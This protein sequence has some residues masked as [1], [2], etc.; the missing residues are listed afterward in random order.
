[1]I[2]KARLQ[3]ILFRSLLL[4]FFIVVVAACK[5]DAPAATAT[6]TRDNY[7]GTWRCTE[8]SNMGNQAFILTISKD[9]NSQ[10]YL[11]FYNFNMQGPNFF[12]NAIVNYA[13]ITIPTQTPPSGG[14]TFN[15][16]GSGQLLNGQLN[17]TYTVND[18]VNPTVSYTAVCIK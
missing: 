17:L 1:M 15:I 7:V 5:K 14:N 8:K 10:A 11:R 12:V 18:G 2:S 13:N 4:I 3:T 16:E 9:P 6:D